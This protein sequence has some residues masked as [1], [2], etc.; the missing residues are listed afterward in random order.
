VIVARL[1]E[2][3][4]A[5]G[6]AFDDSAL[7]QIARAAR[8]SMRDAL[9]VLDQ[10]IAHGAGE[11]RSDAVRAML[12]SVETE[13][14]YRIADA[15][16]DADG[17]AMLAESNALTARSLSLSSALDELAS[18]FHRIAV[19]QTVPE[20][21]DALPDA[22]H[23]RR[24]AT[25]LSPEAVQLAYQICVQGR[26]DLALAPDEATGFV[27]TLLRLLAFEPATGPSSGDV[28]VSARPRIDPGSAPSKRAV[29]QA[30]KGSTLAAQPGSPAATPSEVEAPSVAGSSGATPPIEIDDWP[31]FVAGMK[32]SGIALQ[33]AAQTELKAMAGNEIVLSVPEV[34]RH[35]TDRAYADKLKAAV[36]EALGKRV[37]MRFEFGAA[38]TTTLAAQEKRKRSEAQAST[39][40]AFRDDP[41]VQDILERFNA[42]V[43]PDSIKPNE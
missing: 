29:P 39:E 33:L 18:L 10:A 15:L 26:A 22:E 21:T 37:R 38:A 14:I 3:L 41:F 1:A 30:A 13:H 34:S 43:R 35:L 6:I 17:P 32:L 42:K 36:E 11:V 5:E 20:T 23:V 16:L 12:G 31:A 27:M 19:A 2:I 25:R 9:S 4:T 40:A 28:T 24:Y 8:G 7:L